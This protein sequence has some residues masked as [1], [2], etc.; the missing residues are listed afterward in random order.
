VSTFTPCADCGDGTWIVFDRPLCLYCATGTSKPPEEIW[1]EPKWFD[2]TEDEINMLLD[3]VASR[4]QRAGIDDPVDQ[5]RPHRSTDYLGT[6]AYFAMCHWLQQ[7]FNP[8]VRRPGQ[9]HIFRTIPSIE[10]RARFQRRGDLIYGQ[11]RREMEADLVV[12]FVPRIVTDSVGAVGWIER[13]EFEERFEWKDLGYGDLRAVKQTQ[14][15]S[16]NEFPFSLAD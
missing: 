14:L 3:L 9:G 7:P 15:H 4:E 8:K 5:S 12:L 13:K 10:I 6:R 11:Y 1:P 16:M 2:F